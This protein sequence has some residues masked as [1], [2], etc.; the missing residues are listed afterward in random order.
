LNSE[1]D[2]ELEPRKDGDAAITS[3]RA[4]SHRVLRRSFTVLGQ[5]LFAK[6]GARL[7]NLDLHVA[8]SDAK[9]WWFTGQV[10]LRPTPVKTSESRVFKGASVEA[11]TALAKS[12]ISEERIAKIIVLSDVGKDGRFGRGD[13]PEEAIE[14]ARKAL[15]EGAY[16]ESKPEVSGT[17]R[18]GFFEMR[19]RKTNIANYSGITI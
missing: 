12:E 19:L 6:M 14:N 2:T 9:H 7:R 5:Y 4:G 18:D 15:P 10:P 16:G 3:E 8:A 1:E 17:K 11:A 13:T